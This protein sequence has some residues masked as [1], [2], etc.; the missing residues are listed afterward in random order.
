MK[1]KNILLLVLSL[2]IISSSVF[3]KEQPVKKFKAKSGKV[4]IER[5]RYS[6]K[7]S[8]KKLADGTEE[9]VREQ[10]PYVE[11]VSEFTFDDYGAIAYEVT[12]QVS[13][14]G[15]KPLDEK[16]KLYEKLW[17][18]NRM[19]IYNVKDMAQSY[20]NNYDIQTCL[21]NKEQCKKYGLF[22]AEHPSLKPI[23][24]EVVAGQKA[25]LYH[26]SEDTDF[27]VWNGIVVKMMNYSVRKVN[28]KYTRSEISSARIAKVIDAKA[29]IDKNIFKP[30]WLQEN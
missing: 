27:T 24:K 26:E 20:D 14:F 29:K 9:S 15:G 17:K 6:T 21:E 12:Y 2:V 25:D 18:G 16:V 5:L 13:K 3:A 1:L 28:G 4:V 10:I 30:E 22:G 8:Y 7:M 19:Y 23:G 11:E